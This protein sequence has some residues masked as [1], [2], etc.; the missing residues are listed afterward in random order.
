MFTK[1]L[2][3]CEYVT[4]KKTTRDIAEQYGCSRFSVSYYLHKYG[5]CTQHRPKKSQYDKQ[6]SKEF[7]TTLYITQGKSINE[8]AC[9]TTIGKTAIRNAIKRHGIKLRP[10]GTRANKKNKTNKN[11]TVVI[12]NHKYGLLLVREQV[13]GGWL[14]QCDCGNTKITTTSRLLN[15]SVKSCGCLLKLKGYNH[16]LFKGYKQ[17]PFTFFKHCFKQASD[18]QISF[19]I[20]IEDMY[21]Q[22]RKQKGLCAITKIKLSFGTN[23]IRGTASLDRI[24]SSKGYSIDNIQWVHKT[25]NLMKLDHPQKIFIKWCKLVSDNN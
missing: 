13:N 9:E 19:N 12:V 6:L 4:N 24:D 5:I 15:G 17:I 1:E 18:R 16:K 7:L 8:I 11:Q 23:R 14:C 20:N 21:N 2:L 25:I 3:F 10:F 22:F